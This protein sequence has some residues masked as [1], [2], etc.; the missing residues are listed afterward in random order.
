MFAVTTA[1][2][3]NW[4]HACGI[5]EQSAWDEHARFFEGLLARGIV[6]LGGPISSNGG[7]D[8]ALLAVEAADEDELRSTFGDDPWA[9]NGV[10]LIKEVRAWT[11]WLD[12]R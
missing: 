7:D 8:V 6:V 2:G 9:T 10:L 3:P 11:L 5:R 4:S 1:K 12:G